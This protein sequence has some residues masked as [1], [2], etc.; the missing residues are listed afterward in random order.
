MKTPWANAVLLIL[1]LVQAVTGYFGMVNGRI[2]RAWILWAHG[3]GA[4]ALVVLLY[5]KG[6][7]ILDAIRRK[8]VW[9]R[10]RIAFAGMLVFC[11]SSSALAC[12]GRLAGRFIWAALAW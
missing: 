8:T 9:T 11:S 4:Y 3:I 10:R 7:I 1:I 12:C 6:G 5:W 2:S